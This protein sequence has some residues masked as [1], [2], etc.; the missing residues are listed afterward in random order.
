MSRHL[1]IAKPFWK[2]N[3][4]AFLRAVQDEIRNHASERSFEQVFAFARAIL[5]VTWEAAREVYEIV[6]QKDR[7]TSSE[8]IMAA[9]STLVRMS[10]CR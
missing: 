3:S 7:A 10:S 1:E 8:F 4:K 5:E 9:R 2:R 6:I